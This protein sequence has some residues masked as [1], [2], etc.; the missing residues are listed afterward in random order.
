MALICLYSIGRRYSESITPAKVETSTLRERSYW[1][2]QSR[3]IPMPEP[4]YDKP[5]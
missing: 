2:S 5:G 1:I 3:N 4:S